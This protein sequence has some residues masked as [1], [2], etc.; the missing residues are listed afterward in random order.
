MFVA[1][2]SVLF[3]DSYTSFRR[4]LRGVVAARI[5]DLPVVAAS[6]LSLLAT[7]AAAEPP[8]DERKDHLEEI[9]VTASLRP[10]PA[11]Q[12]AA[13]TTVLSARTL[14]DAGMQ[15]FE[16]VLALVPNLNWAG[17][18]SRPRYFQLRGIGELEQ[19]QGAP[20]PSI[21]FLVDEIDFSGIGMIASTFDVEQVEVLRGPQGTRYGANAL[22]GLIK[23]KTR[24]AVPVRELGT[25][26]T[27]GGDGLWSAGAVAGGGLAAGA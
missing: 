9:V 14:H 25:E 27:V 18:T 8:A 23:V 7:A 13:S 10:E 12:F 11:Q 16:D 24:D 26:L 4:L 5:A 20:N 6:V 1:P 15:H 21:G 22:G 19:Y 2:Y 17:G 3:S